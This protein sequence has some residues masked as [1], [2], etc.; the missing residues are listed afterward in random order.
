MVAAGSV[1]AGLAEYVH[2]AGRGAVKLADTG[3]RAIARVLDGI[4]VGLIVGIC[5][6]IGTAMAAAGV[7]SSTSSYDAYSGSFSDGGSGVLAGMGAM[8]GSVVAGMLLAYA[9]E[10]VMV[11]LWGQ[12][13][14]KMIMKIKVV[15]ASN[16]KTPNIGAAFVRYLI[17][18][19]CSLIPFV[20]FLGTILCFLSAT[21]DN[22]GRRQGWHDKI[23]GTYVVSSR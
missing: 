8:L 18:G 13:L 3:Q 7:A 14:G 9:Y 15:R 1:A 11:G 17:P 4:I 5:I 10:T 21:F 12:T 2:I 23:A 6:A 20:G 16:G 22:S 19:L